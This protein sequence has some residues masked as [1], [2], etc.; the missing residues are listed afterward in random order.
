MNFRTSKITEQAHRR[1]SRQNRHLNLHSSSLHHI[2][3]KDS[4][5]SHRC[6]SG[7]CQCPRTSPN[8]RSNRMMSHPSPN[9][10]TRMKNLSPSLSCRMSPSRSRRSPDCRTQSSSRKSPRSNRRSLDCKSLSSSPCL[11]CK[12]LSSSPS[13]RSP[14]HSQTRLDDQRPGMSLDNSNR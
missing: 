1:L 10:H 14:S 8:H 5:A 11:N 9:H 2:H 13:R 3:R 6:R 12:S 4:Q 7:S